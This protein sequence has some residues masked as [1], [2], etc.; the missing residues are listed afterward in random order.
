MTPGTTWSPFHEMLHGTRR[1]ASEDRLRDRVQ[2]RFD[3]SSGQ[4]FTERIMRA[5]PWLRNTNWASP[6]INLRRNSRAEI[7][8]ASSLEDMVMREVLRNIRNVD[9]EALEGVPWQLAGKIWDEAD[10][11]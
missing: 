10:K 1:K 4:V 6:N 8:G 3:M 2:R 7:Y 11:L 9:S 5:K